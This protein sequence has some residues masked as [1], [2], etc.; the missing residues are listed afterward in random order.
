MVYVGR[1]EFEKAMKL[2]V[3]KKARD[4]TLRGTKRYE[5][6]VN[7]LRMLM[8][9]FRTQTTHM[10]RGVGQDL[11]ISESSS[12]VCSANSTKPLEAVITAL[13]RHK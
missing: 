2:S 4:A 10:G 12:A 8:W 6:Q 5:S 7:A 3:T 1:G 13:T 9:T 11:K